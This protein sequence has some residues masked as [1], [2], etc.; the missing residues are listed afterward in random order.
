[1][2]HLAEAGIGTGIHYP[3]PLHLQKA[4]EWLG[5]REGD[6]PV[7]EEAAREIVSLPMF[8]QLMLVSNRIVLSKQ[9]RAFFRL[10]L[11]QL[12]G[13]GNCTLL[14]DNAMPSTRTSTDAMDG[15]SER[16]AASSANRRIWIDLDNSPHVPFFVPIIEEL[17]KRGYSVLV[18]ARDC[19][20]VLDLAR[21]HGL[22]IKVIGRHYGKSRVLKIAGL[23]VRA[24]QLAPTV[25][26]ERPHIAISHGSRAQLLTCWLL[27]VPSVV[28]FD[29]EF[30]RG[31]GSCIPDGRCA[32]RS[33][34][35]A[36]CVSMTRIAF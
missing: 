21:L 29:Y 26:R 22:G 14:S 32:R 8:P 6:F 34:L 31:W 11:W 13:V 9:S 36:Q 1:M 17:E 25:L 4:Y 19:F 7:T 16:T 23:C 12:S 2:R 15:K 20:Q 33:S 30:A 28:I 24:L 10:G 27:R 35:Q 18:T 3:V 5:Y